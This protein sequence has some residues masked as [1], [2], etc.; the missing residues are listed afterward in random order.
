MKI[1]NKTEDL[2]D[3]GR[4]LGLEGNAKKTM[5]IFTS[6]HQTTEENY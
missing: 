5:Y 2:L 4:E 6:R 3:A 1:I